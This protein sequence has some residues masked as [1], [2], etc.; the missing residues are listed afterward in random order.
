MIYWPAFD[1]DYTLEVSRLLPHIAVIEA[2][3]TAASLRIRP[4]QWRE[5]PTL[6]AGPDLPPETDQK[7]LI[8][9]IKARKDRAR[10]TNAGKDWAWAKERFTPG[11]DPIS[12]LDIL[13]MHCLVA[14]ETGVRYDSAGK[15]RA[16]AFRVIVGSRDTGFHVGAPAAKVPSLMDRYVQF[17]NS[18]AL[19]SMPAAIQALVAHYFFTTIHP[20]DDG[21]GRVSRLVA[22]AILFRKGYNGHGFYALSSHFY[23]NEKRYHLLIFQTQQRP[24]PDLTE[25]VAF[26]LEGLVAELQGINNFIKVRLERAVEREVL[27]PALRNKLEGREYLRHG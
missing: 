27:T 26:G 16:D 6:D 7:A 4:P 11:S 19:I 1:F 25:F 20:F 5:L 8:A 14:E 3:R 18:Y 21:N 10:L 9:Q 2:F 12:L 17:I 23:H 22:A 24:C 15:L 13:H